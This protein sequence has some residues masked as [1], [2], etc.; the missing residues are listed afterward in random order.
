MEGLIAWVVIIIG[1]VVIKT[2]FSAA[3]GGG[4]GSV[5]DV[6]RQELIDK[7]RLQLKVTEEVPPKYEGSQSDVKKLKK[8]FVDEG[9]W[10]NVKIEFYER[11][12][13]LI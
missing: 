4:S 13:G 7:I 10:E 12:V 1:W 11:M 6:D 5:S 8:Y 3:F 9:T 2:I